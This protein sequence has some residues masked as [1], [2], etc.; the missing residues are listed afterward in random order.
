MHFFQDILQLVTEVCDVLQSA[1]QQTAAAAASCGRRWPPALP[2]QRP[3]PVAAACNCGPWACSCPIGWWT[4][5]A[6]FMQI[7]CCEK[8]MP[9]LCN[10]IQI[11]SVNMLQ[12]MPNMQNI[13]TTCKIYAENMLN[14]P[15]ICKNVQK[16]PKMPKNAKNKDPTKNWTNPLALPAAAWRP[17]SGES[18]MIYMYSRIRSEFDLGGRAL[19]RCPRGTLPSGHNMHGEIF[20]LSL[21]YHDAKYAIYMQAAC[22]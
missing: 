22:G 15:K 20:K 8:I 3:R 17:C 11:Y 10:L 6:D 13:Q 14:M 12:H 21:R 19:G 5:E 9:N 16:M 18:T 2:R 7:L 1:L 4:Y